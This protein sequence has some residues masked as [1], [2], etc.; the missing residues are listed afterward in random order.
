MSLS[1]RYRAHVE[2]VVSPKEVHVLYIDFGNVR[3]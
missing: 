1:N 3:I 2:K